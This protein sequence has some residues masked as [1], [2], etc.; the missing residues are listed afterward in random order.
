M[1]GKIG[2]QSSKEPKCSKDCYESIMNAGKLYT[3]LKFCLLALIPHF[4]PS[5][6][7]HLPLP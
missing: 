3:A 1:T 2:T 6:L 5:Y 7:V 4:I